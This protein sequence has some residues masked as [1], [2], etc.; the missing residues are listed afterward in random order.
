MVREED[1]NLQ[2]RFPSSEV[3]THLNPSLIV[4]DRHV[5]IDSMDSLFRQSDP[6]N[7]TESKSGISSHNSNSEGNQQAATM[8]N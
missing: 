2:G 3:E 4:L 6:A 8:V 5:L 1:Q 7:T